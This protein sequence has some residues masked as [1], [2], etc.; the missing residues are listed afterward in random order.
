M[1]N[2]LTPA[3]FVKKW[4]PSQLKESASSQ[5]HF[6]DICALVR[7]KPPV[8]ADPQGQFFTFQADA[9]K[10]QGERGF[11]DAWYKNHFIWEYK[12][13]HKNLQAA[14]QQLLLYKDSL[15]NPPLLI[16][17]DMQVIEIH[18]NF[19]NTVKKTYQIKLD[20]RNAWLNPPEVGVTIPASIV[21]RRTLTNLYNA[22][23]IYR[24]QF[25]GKQRFAQQWKLAVK[26]I[27]ELPDIEML[28][29]IHTTLD[30]AVLDA[31][32]WPHSLS[33]EQILERLLALNLQRAAASPPRTRPPSS[34]K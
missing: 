14:Y 11:A 29:H 17:S 19:T 16:T 31:Y 12:G 9:E 13:P 33:D 15:G 24:Q 20:F 4:S 23:T 3:Q 25:K 5:S 2:I 6:L 10:P 8:E 18:T 30:N 21:A 22:L 32:G 34:A 28:D 1:P 27:I 26:D 7:Q